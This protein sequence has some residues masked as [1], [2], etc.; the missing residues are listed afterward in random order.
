MVSR[1]SV[2]ETLGGAAIGAACVGLPSFAGAGSPSFQENVRVAPGSSLTLTAAQLQPPAS[3]PR[4]L[5]LLGYSPPRQGRIATVE[6]TSRFPS[7]VYTPQQGFTGVDAFD[8]RY[9]ADGSVL[10]TR[11]VVTVEAGGAAAMAFPSLGPRSGLPFWS[12][13]AEAGGVADLESLRNRPADI[14]TVFGKRSSWFEVRGGTPESSTLD[15]WFGGS[16]AQFCDG[17]VPMVLS[18][19]YFPSNAGVGGRAG[20][21]AAARGAYDAAWKSW[22]AKLKLL[23]QRRPTMPVPVIRPGWEANVNSYPWRV[24]DTDPGT[25]RAVWQRLVTILRA[26]HPDAPICWCPLKRSALPYPLAS[27]WPGADYVDLVGVD[28][29]ARNMTPPPVSVTAFRAFADSGTATE[30]CGINRWLEFA[31]TNGKP[32]CLPEWGIVLAGSRSPGAHGDAPAFLDG[33]W[34]F[35]SDNREAIAFENY[36]D[37]G[38]NWL[39]PRAAP[40]SRQRYQDLWS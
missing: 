17:P 22:S 34:G 19:A 21:A 30:P 38:L 10:T 14:V 8:V 6:S 35:L 40:R 4:T 36:F 3:S 29:Y 26:D 33:M 20:Y 24:S 18:Y 7:L 2:I 23:R 9:H 12:G 13:G 32:L 5:L 1:R 39:S 37:I 27:Y 28:Y 31:Q 11:V 25:Y 15:G 16:F